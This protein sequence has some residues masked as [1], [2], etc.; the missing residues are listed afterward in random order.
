MVNLNDRDI[1]IYEILSELK[2]DMENVEDKSDCIN[3]VTELQQEFTVKT[4]NDLKIEMG[5]S[6]ANKENEC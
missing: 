4:I 5:L 3:L 2:D 6:Y 1:Y